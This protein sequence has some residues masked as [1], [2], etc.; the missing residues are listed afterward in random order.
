[1][2]R[3]IRIFLLALSC[4]ILLCQS[5]VVAST[6]EG[7]VEEN[8]R[9]S[10]TERGLD[11]RLAVKISRQYVFMGTVMI[12]KTQFASENEHDILLNLAARTGGALGAV[13]A[14]SYL[15]YGETKLQETASVMMHSARAGVFPEVASRT[16]SELAKN[17]YA[18]DAT[19]SIVHDASELV[20]ALRMP[21]GGEVMCARIMSLAGKNEPVGSLKNDI[22][23]LARKEVQKQ[24]TLL[25]K[26]EAE[27]KKKE[28]RG[29]NGERSLTASNGNG[30]SSGNAS[31]GGTGA[32]ASGSSPSG[33][34]SGSAA[35][36]PSA[37]GASSSG[38][39]SGSAA[40]GSS[41]SGS[42]ASGSSES[43][44]SASS[45]SDSGSA[46]GG[47]ASGG[48]SSGSDSGASS[49]GSA[50]DSGGAAS[51]SDSASSSSG[52]GSDSSS[53]SDGDSSESSSDS[54][55]SNESAPTS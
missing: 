41:S 49:G 6:L 36:G 18:F 32:A 45:G 14:D 31:R 13:L 33:P 1:M 39:S 5:P 23:L 28:A 25:A 24:K 53:S 10:L 37:S 7:V 30:A 27:R 43:S 35:S 22:E 3:H 40:S 44:G 55:S 34:S 17:G 21:D 26:K 48:A 29:G 19:V 20:R 52:S 11:E 51:G 9:A 46:S 47:S 8:M 38:P 50:S 15:I 4:S 54:D 16:F 42:A 2:I 12:N